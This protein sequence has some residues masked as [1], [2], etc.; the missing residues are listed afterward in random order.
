VLFVCE[1]NAGRSQFAAGL[2]AQ[3][4]QLRASSAGTDPDAE[5]DDVNAGLAG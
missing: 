1:H 2:A 3:H 5:V 4:P